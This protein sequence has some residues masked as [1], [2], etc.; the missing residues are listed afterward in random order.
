MQCDDM[1][2]MLYNSES[3]DMCF[4]VGMIDGY[5]PSPIVAPYEGKFWLPL[6][7]SQH[8][9]SGRKYAAEVDPIPK[10]QTPRLHVV[11]AFSNKLCCTKYTVQILIWRFL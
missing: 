1:R 11:T 6:C 2:P 5:L 4:H 7:K 3:G 9:P 8:R 10:R